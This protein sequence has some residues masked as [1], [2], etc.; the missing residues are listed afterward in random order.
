MTIKIAITGKSGSGK[1]D[2]NASRFEKSN[3]ERNINGVESSSEDR[4][5]VEGENYSDNENK[6]NYDLYSDTP[7]GALDG[8]NTETYLTN[9]RKITDTN[10]K[11]GKKDAT[12]VDK[13]NANKT[14]AEEHKENSEVTNTENANNRNEYDESGSK[15]GIR[16]GTTS[17]DRSG[18]SKSSSNV[19]ENLNATDKYNSTESYLLHV[20][21]KQAG[22]SYS[23][24]LKEFRETFLNIDMEIINALGDLFINLWWG[25]Y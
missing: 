2:A 10:T 11:S 4:N 25:V 12:T 24:L 20:T 9:A 18:R 7:Q 21:G 23:K 8:V 3:N 5:K 22:A 19:N 16:T 6:I 14:N 15:Y 1:T 17:D 13:N